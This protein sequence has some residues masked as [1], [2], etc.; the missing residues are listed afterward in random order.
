MFEDGSPPKIVLL[1]ARGE[2][3]AAPVHGHMLQIS[4][5]DGEGFKELVSYHVP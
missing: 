3:C 1:L 2:K 5:V 4:V